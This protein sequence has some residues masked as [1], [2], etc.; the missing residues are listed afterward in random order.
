MAVSS[1]ESNLHNVPTPSPAQFAEVLSKG[2]CD[3]YSLGVYLGASFPDLDTIS[4]EYSS[5]GAVRCLIELY[6]CLETR[7]KSL[8]WDA[9]VKALEGMQFHALAENI[10]MNYTDSPHNTTSRSNKVGGLYKFTVALN[11]TKNA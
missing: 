8:S 9:I 3:W 4:H 1:S 10:Q 11:A 7:G 6:K 5:M 2:G